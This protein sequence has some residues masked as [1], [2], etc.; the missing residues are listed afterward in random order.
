MIISYVNAFQYFFLFQNKRRLEVFDLSKENRFNITGEF[1]VEIIG[2]KQNYKLVA[3]HPNRTIVWTS[4]Y[5]SLETKTYQS[6]KIELAK[7]VWLAYN[8]EVLNHTKGDVESQELNTKVSYPT[9]DILLGGSYLLKDDSFDT[10]VTVKWLKKDKSS[11]DETNEDEN[12]KLLDEQKIIQAKFQWRDLEA[13]LKNKDHQNIILALKHPSFDKDVTLQGSYYRDE[14]NSAK[15]EV[16]FDYTED[17]DHHAN[18][19]TSVKN[20]SKDVGYKNYTIY[21][22]ATHVASELNLLFDGSIGLKP[23]NYIMEATGNYKRGY[24]PDVKLELEG[25]FDLDSKKLKFYVS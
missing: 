11:E 22:T 1:T 6:S 14:L 18:F 4:D 23:N 15:I 12:A 24:L 16:D 20:L 17:E 7:N 8:I 21:V 10:D 25:F 5:C 19:I 13:N 2:E 3:I 9:R